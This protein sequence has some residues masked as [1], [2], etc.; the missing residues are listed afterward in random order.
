M[1]VGALFIILIHLHFMR[2]EQEEN[3]LQILEENNH[4]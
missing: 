4:G 1:L 3:R 2:C